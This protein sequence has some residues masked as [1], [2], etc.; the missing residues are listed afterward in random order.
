MPAGA[1][2]VSPQGQIKFCN[3]AFAELVKS[4]KAELLGLSLHRFIEDQ[5]L[6]F[7][8]Q[9]LRAGLNTS[10]NGIVPM[11]CLDGEIV[12]V[13][14]SI[15]TTRDS[16]E[17]L[18][19]VIC[20]EFS[21]EPA[22]TQAERRLAVIFRSAFDA[23]IEISPDGLVLSWNA[24][25]ERFFQY[26]AA[27]MI[28]RPLATI[29]P[30]DR[31]NELADILAILCAGEA[32]PPM[33]KECVCGDGSRIWVR[34]A[35]VPFK[36]KEGR[37]LGATIFLQD[38]SERK[39][40][41]RQ[42]SE[43][44]TVKEM[45]SG[46]LQA[47]FDFAPCSILMV[48]GDGLVRF[49]NPCA[50][51]MLGYGQAELLNMS[52]DQFVPE[53]FRSGHH[54]LVAAYMSNPRARSLGGSRTLLAQRKNGSTV[55]VDI[56]L[57]PVETEDGQGVLVTMVDI[58]EHRQAEEAV[59]LAAVVEQRDQ[60]LAML[61]HDLKN[62]LL[63]SQ[64]L[65]SF[66]LDGKVG[67]F[68]DKQRQYL[69]ML[70]DSDRSALQL[71]YNVLD[72]Y[73][74]EGGAAVLHKAPTD[75][76]ELVRSSCAEI[77][78][79]A[80]SR[81]IAISTEFQTLLRPVSLDYAAM[82]RVLMNLLDNAQKFTPEGGS[83]V[84]SVCQTPDKV[85]IEVQDSGPGVRA[86]EEANLFSRFWQG[87]PSLR[88][89]AGSGL[90][91]Y[92]CKELVHA[93]GGEISYRSGTT[94]GAVFSIVL[95]AGLAAFADAEKEDVSSP[96]GILVVDDVAV[97]RYGLQ[98]VLNAVPGFTVLGEA[99]DGQ[100]ALQLAAELSPTIVVLDV[101][102]PDINGIEVCRQIKSRHGDVKVLMLTSYGDRDN[103]AAALAAGAD[104]YCLKDISQ[105]N[106]Q[107]ALRQVVAGAG[108]FDPAL[109][110]D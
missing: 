101:G 54:S 97:V 103:V 72:V 73:R 67:A 3:G 18:L 110:Y 63:G 31:L 104:G 92:V 38:L 7:F 105:E 69:E 78:T 2:L 35:S 34:G 65:F 71:I 81:G 61:S 12:S 58:S 106:L 20:T 40:A 50:A 102:L 57:T 95:P 75:L 82:R 96:I 17:A 51:T 91:L 4:T 26:T 49:A 8:Q 46:R 76:E 21:E 98:A 36:D 19:I 10:V 32:V 70:R 23:I 77:S 30:P 83:I 11:R 55:E 84:V 16:G 42:V 14:L 41:D 25:A 13:H 27:E 45:L 53:A 108:W 43:L 85:N 29:V 94:G 59:R 15:Q 47:V 90:G 100:R 99:A 56:G 88:H 109:E 22:T 62:P 37:V 64:R 1:L 48:G 93:H 9:L 28:G 52:V 60:F 87:E 39:A 33:E 89:R 5:H 80:S 68:S 86:E 24:A 66:L 107:R 44:K 79:V 6:S 74:A